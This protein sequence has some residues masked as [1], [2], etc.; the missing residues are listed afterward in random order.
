MWK[1]MTNM[2]ECATSAVMLDGEISKYI[3]IVQ[4]V[5]QECT[6]SPNRFKVYIDDMIVSVEA[7]N[8]RV[9]MA[10]H[11]MSGLMFADGFVTNIRNTRRTAETDK[12]PTHK[13]TLGDGE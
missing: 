11:T 7:A 6:L 13:S 10:E 5:A 8:Q 3:G 2:T 4:G 1:M 12:S 9:T